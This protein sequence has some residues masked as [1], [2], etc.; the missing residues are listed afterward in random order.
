[1]SS[2]R[3]GLLIL[4][5]AAVAAAPLAAQA[6]AAVPATPT[7]AQMLALQD[8]YMATLAGTDMDKLDD[9]ISE[10]VAYGHPTGQV[11]TKKIQMD[12]MRGGPLPRYGKIEQLNTKV[13]VYPGA[14]VLSGD[15]RFTGLPRNG[16]TPP[17]NLYRLATAYANEGGTW[18]LVLWQVTPIAPPRPAAPPAQ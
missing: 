2:S 4:A 1:M 7:E 17:P 10:T 9:M 13:R 16:V 12:S 15:I 14:A 18:R 8:R 11:N 5:V 3:R 6:R